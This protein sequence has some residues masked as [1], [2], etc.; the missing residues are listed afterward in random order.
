MTDVSLI[1]LS[2]D[3][4]LPL[5]LR[6]HSSQSGEINTKQLPN[7]LFFLFLYILKRNRLHY[8]CTAYRFVSA[9]LSSLW[10]SFGASQP[11]RKAQH[12]CI[13]CFFGVIAF[14]RVFGTLETSLR[15]FVIS[16]RTRVEGY[17]FG[18]NWLSYRNSCSLPAKIRQQ[19]KNDR[20]A[21]AI[22]VI[23]EQRSVC[24]NGHFVSLLL[25]ICYHVRMKGL[26]IKTEGR[27]CFKI[28]LI[29]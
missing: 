19:L 21:Q 24:H 4:T 1:S 26:S 23:F 11:G 16:F 9:S 29:C 2:E 15:N 5:A 18:N 13:V 27:R 25:P 3:R 14:S 12:A 17:S 6:R 20:I 7:E 10:Y 22:A 28:F 8:H